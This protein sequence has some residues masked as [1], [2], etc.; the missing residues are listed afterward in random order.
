MTIFDAIDATWPPARVETCGPF[1]V[2]VGRGGGKR[3]SAASTS[4]VTSEAEVKDAEI[5]M[6]EIGQTPLFMVRGE[7]PALDA[8]LE[9]LDYDIVDPVVVL[10]G[11]AET[12]AGDGPKP[13][14]AFPIWPPLTVM[15]ELWAE[16]GIGPERL[17]V[18]NRARGPK[19]G[20]LGRAKDHP[21]GCAFLSLDGHV[22]MLHALEVLPDFRRSGCATNIVRGAATWAFKEGA[23]TFAVLTTRANTEAQALFTSLGMRPVEQYHYRIHSNAEAPN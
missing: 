18:M 17:A 10:S 6:K 20:V 8:M 5:R 15:T 2:R 1:T 9:A 16:T 12:V 7:Q 23:K 14:T 19:T 21:A 13:V 22:A 3:V 4:A 11:P